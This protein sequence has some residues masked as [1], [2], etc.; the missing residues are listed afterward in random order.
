MMNQSDLSRT[1]SGLV[2]PSTKSYLAR[3][4]DEAIAHAREELGSEATLLNTRKL[5]N[6]Q[7]QPGGY[8]VV[9][10]MPELPPDPRLR[11]PRVMDQPRTDPR[12]SDPRLLD[13]R[14]MDQPRPDQRAS[15]PRLLDPRVMDQPRPDQRVSDPRLADPRVTDQPRLAASPSSQPALAKL[16]RTT[17]SGSAEPI[18]VPDGVEGQAGPARAPEDLA[19][20][21]E[22]LHSQMDEIR[23]L[24]MRP[25]KAQFTPVRTAPDLADLY[26][27][28]V[29]SE[30]EP[31]L[32]KDIV[33]RLEANRSVD[34]HLQRIAARREK[35]HRGVSPSSLNDPPDMLEAFVLAELERRVTIAPRLGQN[36]VVLVG[37]PGAGKTTTVAKL[38]SFVS[39]LAETRPVRLVSLDTSPRAV[40]LREMAEKLGI[41]LTKVPAIHLL[42]PLI[43]E[44]R[45][46]E[47]LLI[48]TPGY[49]SADRKAAEAA[50]AALAECPGI[51]IHLV[52]PGYMKS[53]D[54]RRCIQRYQIFRPSKLLV[55]KLDETHSFGSV[56]SE[57]ARA[58]LALSFLAHGPSIPGDIRPASSEDLLALAVDRDPARPANVA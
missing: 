56:F 54:L 57:A 2:P 9:F 21:L 12:A 47:F 43:A 51:D 4:V 19:A 32:S 35:G 7:G 48:D 22:R 24:L 45:T 10:G 17:E 6:E 44:V 31:A 18:R 49:V 38:A 5:A 13:P 40:R 30:V 15:D 55:T 23:N 53:I 39:D 36:G 25:T 16:A 27:C 33:D 14:V 34:A 29:S 11:D 3:S 28:L 37:P 50:A 1:L 52:V 26:D 58:G 20:D 42:A 8:E 46:A 41:A